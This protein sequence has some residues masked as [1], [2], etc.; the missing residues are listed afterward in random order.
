MDGQIYGTPQD[1]GAATMVYRKDVFDKYK[2]T[3]PKTWAEFETQA[4]KLHAADPTITALS[5]P[6]NWVLGP[7]GLG[8]AG[9]SQ[10][11]RLRER[12]VVHQFHQPDRHEG[13]QLLGEDDPKQV[14]ST[15]TT[16][17]TPTGTRS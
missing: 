10:A 4:N 16:G 7:M 14:W 3:V 17:G 9:R 6:A 2:L 15:A 5:F 8:L 1:S 13:L 12:Q 11:V